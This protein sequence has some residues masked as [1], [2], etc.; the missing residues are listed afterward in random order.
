MAKSTT[1]ERLHDLEKDLA[2]LRDKI[3]T[4]EETNAR[5]LTERIATIE[6]MLHINLEAADSKNDT[7]LAASDSKWGAMLAASESKSDA[8]LAHFKLSMWSLVGFITAL[9]G[10]AGLL[11]IPK[12]FAFR[13]L[14]ERQT[15]FGTIKDLEAKLRTN[16]QMFDLVLSNA[17]RHA[18]IVLAADYSEHDPYVLAMLGKVYEVAPDITTPVYVELPPVSSGAAAAKLQFIA[19]SFPSNSVI[20]ALYNPG[21]QAKDVF[22]SKLASGMIL[23]AYYNDFAD[24]FV[25]LQG[26]CTEAHWLRSIPGVQAHADI[27]L[28]GLAWLAPAAAKLAMRSIKD[29]DLNDFGPSFAYVPKRNYFLSSNNQLI[30]WILFVDRHGNCLTSLRSV[31]ILTMTEGGNQPLTLTCGKK[32]RLNYYEH[33]SSATNG[34]LFAMN[35]EGLINLIKKNGSFSNE[36]DAALSEEVKVEK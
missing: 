18:K 27:S 19:R 23:L 30:G 22:V 11:G 3:R 29:P 10:M 8:K 16:A 14:K 1:D 17:S 4:V 20:A 32:L 34:E 33:F 9:I 6:S 35:F 24:A 5:T 31:D 25:Q 36:I 12:Y 21:A 7:K 2:A 26:G 15:E 13:M 28:R